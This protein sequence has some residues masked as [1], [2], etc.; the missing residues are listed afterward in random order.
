MQLPLFEPSDW[1]P[2]T[3]EQLP[4]WADA[5]RVGLDIET[6]DPDLKAMGP[7]VRRGGFIAGVAFTIEDGPSHYLPMR[8]LLGD[9]MDVDEVMRYLMDQ[10]RRF[11]GTLVGANL[12][13]D[14]D[15]LAEVGVMFP[16]LAWQRDI[17]VADPLISELHDSY[18]LEAIAARHSLPGKDEHKLL[19]AA[20]HYGVDP[21]ADLW[22]LP[23]RHVGAYAEQ[24]SRAPLK[25]LRRQERLIQEMGLWPIYDL[26][27]RVQPVLLKMRRRGIKIDQDQLAK[28]EQWSLDRGHEYQAEI[29]RLT[30][31]SIAPDDI[32]KKEAVVPAVQAVGVVLGQTPTGQPKMDKYTLNEIDHPVAELILQA[33]KVNKLRTTFAA[34][35]R[36]HMVNGR[37]HTTFNQLR[38]T[39]ED[40]DDVGARYGRMSSE[41]PNLQQQPARDEFA[42]MWRA[43]YVPDTDILISADY[44]QQEPR[45]LTHFAE[46]CQLPKA[47]Q[48]AEQYRND[49]STDNHAMMTRLVHPETRDWDVKDPKFQALRTP[50]KNIYLGLC[51]GMGGAKLAHDL[52]LP[53]EWVENRQGRMVE[54]AGPEAQFML[55]QFNKAAPF[56]KKL[57]ER[58]ERVA[59]ERGYIKTILGRRCNFPR[60][61]DGSYDWTYKALNRLIQGSSA[62][63]TKQAMVDQDAEGI[64][65]QLQIHDEF[66]WSAMSFDQA[67]RARDVM[68]NCVALNV[69]SKVD[70]EWGPN[71]GYAKQKVA[72]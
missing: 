68:E 12:N 52:G 17:Q 55:D 51:Y 45:M 70:L 36:K 30:G 28:V 5:D 33:R 47:R 7:G 53:T 19:E 66:V 63:Q 11:K 22:K 56:V 29:K 21:K 37:I 60:L 32:W 40:G 49:P 1:R 61:P 59:K 46:L 2:P 34:S 44:S 26:E 9:N 35:I 24:D 13:Y 48:A 23:A 8:H 71:W 41:N 16:Q 15:Y 65:L 57:A 62:D 67:R 27:C 69:P 14:L 20:M 3:L 64:P 38:H 72:A 42:S 31:V 58:C 6:C 43:I 39:R 54:I 10:A 25:I 4:D 50:C 18:S